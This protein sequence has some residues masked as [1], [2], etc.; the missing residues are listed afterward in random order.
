PFGESQLQK[1]TDV[2]LIVDEAARDALFPGLKTILS[3]SA[4]VKLASAAQPG[5]RLVTADLRQSVIK[6]PWVGWSKGAGVPAE[7]SFTV[8]QD[9]DRFNLT[10]FHLKGESFGAS[11]SI[12]VKGGSLAGARFNAVRLNRG[13]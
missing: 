10:D 7:A 2:A 9:G 3:G 5:R 12:D 6:L 13:D 4:K 1:R 11:G 8:D